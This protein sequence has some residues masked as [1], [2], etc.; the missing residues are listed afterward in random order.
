[1]KRARVC[2][3]SCEFHPDVGGVGKSA[4]RIA[5]FLSAGYD[6]EL[7]APTP[8]L[9]PGQ[10]TSTWEHGFRVHRLGK[11]ADDRGTMAHIRQ[12]IERIDQQ[13]PFSIFHGFYLSSAKPC[14]EV[15]NGRPVIA[16]IRGNDA[17]SLRDKP[18]W[19]EAIERIVED[20]TWVTSVASE[21]LTR[22]DRGRTRGDTCS[23]LFNSID[24]SRHTVRW[25][26]EANKG[27]VG[28]L[29]NLRK[30][31]NLPLLLSGYARIA[32]ALRSNLLIAGGFDQDP[33]LQEQLQ[34]LATDLQVAPQV[35]M[36]GPVAPRDVPTLFGQIYVFAL[37]SDHDGMPNALLE[38]AAAG[39]PLVATAV[40]AIPDIMRSEVD[41]LVIP[42]G[43]PEAL[44]E[45]LARVLSDPGLA[46]RLSLAARRLAERFDYAAE[47][48]E[49]LE[50]YRKL[51]PSPVSSG[52]PVGHRV[53]A[54][55]DDT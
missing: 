14:L 33:G 54:V 35:T 49:W 42:P 12:L 31:K 32:P 19:T 11:H 24:L 16:S 36:C 50:L 52:A 30:K 10:L 23:T 38:A 8:R 7:I 40:G 21:L 15:S 37:T 9:A 20:A 17:V 18:I 22:F 26:V 1:M 25:D 6:V 27:V 45:A 34:T 47:R 43:Q 3:V 2:F 46:S 5:R 28:T 55:A 29:A 13:S 51:L 44:A 41:G 4:L 53:L 39:V 48:S